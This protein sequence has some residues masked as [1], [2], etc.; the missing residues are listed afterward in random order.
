MKKHAAK[1]RDRHTPGL[2]V[3]SEGRTVGNRSVPTGIIA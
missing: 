2:W 1:A 3:S